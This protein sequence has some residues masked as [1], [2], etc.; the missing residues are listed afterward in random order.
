MLKLKWLLN[1][2]ENLDRMQYLQLKISQAT[3]LASESCITEAIPGATV[4]HILAYSVG[5]TITIKCKEGFML[6]EPTTMTCQPGGAWSTA[7]TCQRIG[8]NGKFI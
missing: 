1:V 4:N 7:P 6:I 2:L 5:S 8:N 3:F